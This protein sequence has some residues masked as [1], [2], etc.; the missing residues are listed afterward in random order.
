MIGPRGCPEHSPGL[1]FAAPRPNSVRGAVE[2]DEPERALGVPSAVLGRRDA[3]LDL[4]EL[5]A[6]PGA[7][8]PARIG[9]QRRA[10]L[11]TRASRPAA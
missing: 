8:E 4:D 5:R 2:L 6:S 9:D 1:E 11:M 3:A 7:P 10:R